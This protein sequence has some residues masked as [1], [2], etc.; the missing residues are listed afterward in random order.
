MPAVDDKFVVGLFAILLLLAVLT[1]T[2][3][4]RKVTRG[5]QLVN[6]GSIG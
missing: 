3:L 1:I 6:L 5:L 2:V 4:S